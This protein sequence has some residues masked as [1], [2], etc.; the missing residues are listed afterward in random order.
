EAVVEETAE[1]AEAVVEETAEAAEAVVEETIEVAEAVVEETAEVTEVVAEETAEVVEAVVEETAEVTE[2]VVE[3]TVEVA[4][5]VV[6]E[7]AEVTETAMEEAAVI[8]SLPE[9][10]ELVSEEVAAEA[11]QK[12]KKRVLPTVLAV[13]VI[14]GLIAGN[15][16]MFLRGKNATEFYEGYIRNLNN[17]KSEILA[18]LS[19]YDEQIA[20]YDAV[21]ADTADELQLYYDILQDDSNNHIQEFHTSTPL[22]VLSLSEGDVGH[23]L[24]TATYDADITISREEQGDSAYTEW[25]SGWIGDSLDI[26][27]YPVELGVSTVTYTNNYNADSVTVTI[28]VVE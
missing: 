16:V 3:E 25:G 28:V 1:V 9:G 21:I 27:V 2:T 22:V 12:S 7:T 13:L 4:E 23:F 11:V 10:A 15:V 5:A 6:E 14:V 18:Q 20:E 17:E 19:E 24:L 26:Y 8:A